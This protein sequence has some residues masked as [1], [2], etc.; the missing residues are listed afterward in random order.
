MKSSLVRLNL[1]L[2]AAGKAPSTLLGGPLTLDAARG[3]GALFIAAGFDD[4]LFMHVAVK[5]FESYKFLE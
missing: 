1:R 3:D 5:L 4:G 2:R